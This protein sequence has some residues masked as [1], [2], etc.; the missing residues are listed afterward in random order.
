MKLEPASSDAA[1][2][3]HLLSRKKDKKLK[4]K[5]KKSKDRPLSG[6]RST[7]PMQVETTEVKPVV[8][9][10]EPQETVPVSAF[11]GKP[12]NVEGVSSCLTSVPGHMTAS[13]DHVMPSWLNRM[14]EASKLSKRPS[15]I[16]IAR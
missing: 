6:E 3:G 16:K 4:K 8:V 5:I 1:P 11:F 15:S 7:E 2:P 9:K 13:E 14:P 10:L 12:S